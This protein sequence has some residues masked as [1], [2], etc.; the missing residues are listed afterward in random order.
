M[1]LSHDTTRP[2][3]PMDHW[4]VLFT[5]I[6]DNCTGKR[7]AAILLCLYTAFRYVDIHGGITSD[8]R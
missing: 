4:T 5:C 8:D 2:F 7:S 1:H 3:H 6:I